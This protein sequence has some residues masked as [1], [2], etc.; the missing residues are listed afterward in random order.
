MSVLVGIY[1]KNIEEYLPTLLLELQNLDL[2]KGSRVAFIYGRSRDS[3]LEL[4]E[5]LKL[6]NTEVEIYRE[7]GDLMLKKYGLPMSA[8]IFSDWKEL[9]KEDYFLYLDKDLI[10]I[11]S[12]LVDKLI[13][14]IDLGGD[15][16]A[17]FVWSEDYK[18]FYDHFYFRIY[19]RPFHPTLPPGKDYDVP[20]VVD[21]VSTCFLATREVFLRAS[22][23]NP[24]PTIALCFNARSMGYRVLALPYLE[25]I[26]RDVPMEI[27]PSSFGRYPFGSPI[28][29][30]EKIETI[31]EPSIKELEI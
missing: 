12:N 11:P 16:V 18:Y 23:D 19:N 22:I 26:H 27:L 2:P 13:E 30:D 25:V 7:P 14:A 1:V 5:T 20:I 8:S 29:V 15:I 21:S 10:K 4:L 24:Y 31:G 6:R 9:I 28:S 3:T 17:P